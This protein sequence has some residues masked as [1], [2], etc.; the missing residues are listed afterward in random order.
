MALTA[1][2]FI[3]RRGEFS[4][5]YAADPT[6]VQTALDAAYR[7]TSATMFGADTDEAAMW[8]AAHLLAADPLGSTARVVGKRALPTTLYMQERQRLEGMYCAIG[9][10]GDLT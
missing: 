8:L 2:Q 1:A 10:L 7:Q 3:D 9:G 5:V 4:A 6:R